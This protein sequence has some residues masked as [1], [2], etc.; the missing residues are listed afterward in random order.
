VRRSRRA[1]LQALLLRWSIGVAHFVTMPA[2]AVMF[3]A[4]R[5]LGDLCADRPDPHGVYGRDRRGS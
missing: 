1:T 2:I 5:C 3:A 4:F